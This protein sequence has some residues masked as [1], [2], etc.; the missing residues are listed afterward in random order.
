MGSNVSQEERLVRERLALMQVYQ[1]DRDQESLLSLIHSHLGLVFAVIKKVA[2]PGDDLDDL[3]AEGVLA[4]ILVSRG[5]D[6][7]KGVEFSTYACRVILNQ[8]RRY[9]VRRQGLSR[10]VLRSNAVIKQIVREL[11]AGPSGELKIEEIS[12]RFKSKRGCG[13]SATR[14]RSALRGCPRFLSLSDC[15]PDWC[16]RR[17]G[18][19]RLAYES[20]S[21]P[22]LPLLAREELA[23]LRGE[24]ESLAGEVNS[25][26][27][28]EK[29]RQQFFAHYGLAGSPS[30]N[31][32]QLAEHYHCHEQ[33]IFSNIQTVWRHLNPG[34]S[35]EWLEE[36]QT[37][38]TALETIVEE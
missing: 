1:T 13:L 26:G 19:Q 4:L 12:R 17:R 33:A 18:A 25:L 38:I 36:T 28:S 29:T 35:Q 5:F 11:P 30:Q 20:Y 37:K 6:E 15:N 22:E 10:G 14:I 8:L 27:L 24:I 3:L 21:L 16:R 31:F 32:R 9:Q 7:G 34:F 23:E 2:G